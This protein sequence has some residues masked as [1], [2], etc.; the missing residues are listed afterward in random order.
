M[1]GRFRRWENR[2]GLLLAASLAGCAT[3]DSLPQKPLQQPVGVAVPQTYRITVISSHPPYEVT[4]YSRL[5]SSN[6]ST[7]PWTEDVLREKAHIL[8][9]GQYRNWRWSVWAPT[10]VMQSWKAWLH[11]PAANRCENA[12][13]SACQALDWTLAFHRLYK[14]SAYLLGKPP[15][16]LELRINLLPQ[17]TGFRT[18]VRQ[19]S[20]TGVPLEFTF[21]YPVGMDA[22]AGEREKALMRVMA[23]VGYEF[24]QVEYIAGDSRGPAF[25]EGLQAFLIKGKATS[26]CWALSAPLAVGAGGYWQVEI[27][28]LP[29]VR[30]TIAA[31][32]NEWKVWNYFV[33]ATLPFT[34]TATPSGPIGLFHKPP[35]SG[36]TTALGSALLIRDL[37]QYLNRRLPANQTGAHDIVIHTTDYADMN[38]L[39]AYC[40]GFTNYSG[41]IMQARMPDNMVAQTHFWK[42]TPSSTP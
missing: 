41:D 42:V 28:R 5:P 25:S 11:S 15:L 13:P 24:Q 39:L 12:S 31:K 1:N 35:N 8:E 16:P 22:T 6:S 17:G 36:N 33:L 19:K 10:A 23:V 30:K 18:S 7:P 14:T 37:G 20:S 4:S 40:K 26:T 3:R 27:P 32:Q 9:R 34:I 29:P 2:V 21:D 38:A